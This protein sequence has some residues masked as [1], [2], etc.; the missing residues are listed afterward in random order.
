M[1]KISSMAEKEKGKSKNAC[2]N[3]FKE[4]TEI[5]RCLLPFGA[6][7]FVFLFA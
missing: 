2:M 4:H 1:W 5:R 6:E 3:K 7:Y